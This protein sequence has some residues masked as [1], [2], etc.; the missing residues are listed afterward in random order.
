MNCPQCK[1][2]GVPEESR[3]CPKCGAAIQAKPSTQITMTQEVGTVEGG[4]V[5]G[6]EVEQVT[7]DLTVES[8]VNQIEAK[9]IQG[10]YVDRKVITNNIL[11]LG[12]PHM[13][14]EILQKLMALQG[15]NE[16][17]V[18]NPGSAIVPQ[19]VEHQISEVMA[20]QQ[21]IATRGLPTSPQAL[22]RLGIL[23]A[24]RRDY[25]GALGLF[26]QA[27]QADPEHSDAFEAIAWLQ[28]HRAMDDKDKQAYGAAASKLADA[29]A[30]AKQTDPLDPR[31]LALRGYVFK[32]M[33]QVAEAQREQANRDKYYKE[34]ARLFKH[35]VQLE[36]DDAS[37]QNGLGNVE[38]AL[39]NLDRAI[40]AYEQAIALAPSYVASHHDLAVAFEA[41]MQTDP[42]QAEHWR[43]KAIEAWQITYQLAPNDPGFSADRLLAIGQ[44]ISQLKQQREQA[45]PESR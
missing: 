35:V 13:L 44:H 11:M 3:F 28:Q 22:Y 20:A 19:H 38:Y 41:K 2:D 23:A 39:G 42:A 36:P 26:R 45:Q 31:A 9:I 6:L 21:E 24:Y 16:Q 18:Q 27:G 33:A 4:E 7:G 14:D 43:Q 32:S 29:N 30:A 40:A 1:Y 15:I 10:G 5:T 8:T 25:D 37:A 17:A 34:A 12:D